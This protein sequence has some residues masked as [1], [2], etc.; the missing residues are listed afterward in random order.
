[1]DES[2]SAEFTW[3]GHPLVDMGIATLVAF[4]GRERPEEVTVGDLERFAKEAE[5]ALFTKTLRGHASVVFTSNAPYLQPSFTEERR[6]TKAQELLRAYKSRPEQASVVC[7]YCRRPAAHLETDSGN[8]YREL[9]PMLTGQGVINFFPWGQH[10]LPVCGLCLVALQ[11]LPIGAPS[12][13]GKALVV[14]SDEPDQV[15]TLVKDWLPELLRR[16]Q[17]S[18]VTGE[19]I[20]TWKAPRTRLVERLVDLERRRAFATGPAAFTVYHMSNSGQGPDLRIHFLPASVVGFVRQAQ[21]AAYHQAWQAVERRQWR[22]AR[23]KSTDRDPTP[24]ERPLW[25][26]T[27][28]EA[29]FQLP[30]GA[31]HFVKRYF[32]GPQ[33]TSLKRGADTQHVPLWRLVALFT[34]EVLGMEQERID[35]IR[36]LADTIAEEVM[37]ED[38][39]L[40]QRAYRATP[41]WRIRRLL[42]T[43]S[44]R[45]VQRGKAP[46]LTLDGFLTVFGVTD[47]AEQAGGDWSMVWDL[48]LIRL[49][50]RLHEERWFERHPEA[51]EAATDLDL[52]AEDEEA[53]QLTAG[54]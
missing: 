9:V 16:A 40:F 52:T 44:A 33:F 25:R 32:C 5:A 28:Y 48:V 15:V 30:V 49:I 24:D 37:T 10:G 53:E 6:R 34:S 21:A 36:A 41:Y 11:A 26:N 17:L 29:L 18:S 42:V 7:A 1:M 43:T 19:K 3:T 50:D 45:R 22:A 20:D 23:R 14:A 39:R 27:F 47:D 35:A 31:A 51:A 2:P 12:C 54:A 38:A 4:A 13:E 8:A 46:L